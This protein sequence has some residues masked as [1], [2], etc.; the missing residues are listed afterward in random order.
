[1]STVSAVLSVYRMISKKQKKSRNQDV[2]FYKD[3]NFV[4]KKWLGIWYQRRHLESW[5]KVIGDTI[6]GWQ[7]FKKKLKI[8]VF[9]FK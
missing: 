7:P 5:N 4:A 3:P 8:N 9:Y 6:D 2:F 1:M